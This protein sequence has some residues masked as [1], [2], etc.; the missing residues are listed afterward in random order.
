LGGGICCF[1]IQICKE[2]KTD[3]RKKTMLHLT[4]ILIQGDHH[5]VKNGNDARRRRRKKN[6]NILRTGKTLLLPRQVALE[7][8]EPQKCI[9]MCVRLL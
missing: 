6:N 3:K 8:L 2:D 1:K 5:L 7:N 4:Q 9:L